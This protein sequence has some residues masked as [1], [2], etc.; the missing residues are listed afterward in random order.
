[1]LADFHL[2]TLVSDGDLEPVALL[3]EAHARGV[4][5]LSITDHDA[6]GA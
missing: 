5:Q 1:M 2:H 6:L 4:T 3:R